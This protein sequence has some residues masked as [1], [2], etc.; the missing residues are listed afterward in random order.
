MRE[1]ITAIIVDDQEE[2]CISLSILLDQIEF[3]ELSGWVIRMEDAFDLY[4]K[5]RPDL[6]FLDIEMPEGKGFKLLDRLH[7][8]GHNPAVIFVTGY[9]HYALDAFD[10]NVYGYLVKPVNRE[11]LKE[12]LVRFRNFKLS[13]LPAEDR[14]LKIRF[15]R[16]MVYIP[17]DE[18]LYLQA[19]GNYTQFHLTGKRKEISSKNMG[20]Y[21]DHP[22]L[23]NFERI[24]RSFLVNPKYLYK[25][26]DNNKKITL[27]K[28]DEEIVLVVK[29]H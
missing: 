18:I 24:G 2:A 16:G 7:K 6:V 27:R 19:E 26:E 25:I 14:T 9:D 29:G 3:V 22:Y 20:K 1:S 10:Y 4:I 11:K 5:K 28:N 15:R 12:M 21:A 17:V 23:K 13:G 8:L